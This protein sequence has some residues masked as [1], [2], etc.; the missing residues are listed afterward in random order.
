MIPGDGDLLSLDD[1]RQSRPEHYEALRSMLEHNVT[2]LY[3][4]RKSDWDR[5]FQ[6]EI[7]DRGLIQRNGIEELFLRKMLAE[8][9][10]GRA[11]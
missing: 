4:N 10:A 5:A 8:A 11:L 1:F 6:L 2:L 3:P 9:S 7:L